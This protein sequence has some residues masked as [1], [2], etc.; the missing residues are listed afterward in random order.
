MLTTSRVIPSRHGYFDERNCDVHDAQAVDVRDTRWEA[1]DAEASSEVIQCIESYSYEPRI[2]RRS[3][4]LGS[5]ALYDVA[6][7]LEMQ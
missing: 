5:S 7:Y 3:R 2:L 1:F 6:D 4:L